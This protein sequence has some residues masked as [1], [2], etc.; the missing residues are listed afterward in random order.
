MKK[1]KKEI[2][3]STRFYRRNKTNYISSTQD[4]LQRAA[5]EVASYMK[6]IMGGVRGYVLKKVKAG[7]QDVAPFLFPTEISKLQATINKKFKWDC[8][9]VLQR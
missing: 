6:T 4:F 7:V 8:L 9:V 3:E 2:N 5:Q 1:A